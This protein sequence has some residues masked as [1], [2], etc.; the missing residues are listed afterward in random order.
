MLPQDPPP[1]RLYTSRPVLTL[2]FHLSSHTLEDS[3]LGLRG[4]SL[5]NTPSLMPLKPLV[6]SSEFSSF[7][8]SFLLWVFLI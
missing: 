4:Q 5:F 7:Y 8:I 6:L 3:D 1:P 2:D